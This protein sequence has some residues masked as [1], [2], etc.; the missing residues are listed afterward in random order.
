VKNEKINTRRCP[1][2]DE[3]YAANSERAK[4][5]EHTEPQSGEYRG[6]LLRFGGTY[7]TWLKRTPH[8]KIWHKF[9][10]GDLL[11]GEIPHNVKDDFMYI[12]HYAN[13]DL[14]E[15]LFSCCYC[16]SDYLWFE[17]MEYDEQGN[18]HS[19]DVNCSSEPH[20]TGNKAEYSKWLKSHP[21]KQCDW[22][23]LEDIVLK[24]VQSKYKVND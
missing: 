8:G 24:H 18:I 12:S 16:H 1:I 10:K 6:S 22:Q 23:P 7:D 4:I 14:N 15:C 21:Y 5:H 20:S 9:T 17:V 11:R 3:W 2:C 13:V 19:I